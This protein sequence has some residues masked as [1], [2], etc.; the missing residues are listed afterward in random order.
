ML[1]KQISHLQPVF[2]TGIVH[3]FIILTSV[4]E[5]HIERTLAQKE[6]MRG[7]VDFLS[8]EIPDVQTK[9]TA[10]GQLELVPVKDADS[11]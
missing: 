11:L 5:Q 10:V 7:V 3:G 8:A 9:V 1:A 2:K 4:V 6:L